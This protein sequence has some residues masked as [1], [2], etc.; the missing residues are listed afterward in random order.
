MVEMRG[1]L[2][3]GQ[4]AGYDVVDDDDDVEDSLPPRR[5]PRAPTTSKLVSASPQLQRRLCDQV[6]H[7][8]V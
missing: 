8:L 4:S 1:V 7:V 6:S 2:T 3:A 5:P